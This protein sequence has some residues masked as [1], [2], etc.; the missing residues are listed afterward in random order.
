VI[1]LTWLQ[2]VHDIA[3]VLLL[4]LGPHFVVPALR[5]L[6]RWPF[7]GWLCCELFSRCTVGW[8]LAAHP[9]LC[10]VHVQCDMRGSVAFLHLLFPLIR[11]LNPVVHEFLCQAQV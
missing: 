8:R 10:A 1:M 7:R 4:V 11:E 3:S 5:K 6:L 9:C 2:G